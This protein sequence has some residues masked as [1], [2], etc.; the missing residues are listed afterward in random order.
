METH[1]W[2]AYESLV[3]LV[4]VNNRYGV[5]YPNENKENND[6]GKSQNMGIY[7]KH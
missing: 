2:P 7:C 1:E 5:I 4:V 3:V 6:F